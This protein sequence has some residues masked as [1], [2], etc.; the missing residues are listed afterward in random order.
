MESK[1]IDNGLEV[2]KLQEHLQ[3]T[4]SDITNITHLQL[5]LKKKDKE[6]EE[7]KCQMNCL[8]KVCFINFCIC[9]FKFY[10]YIV[11]LYYY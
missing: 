2:K 9:S 11:Y 5:Q 7:I 4:V 3:D 8:K 10:Y 1:C 6:I